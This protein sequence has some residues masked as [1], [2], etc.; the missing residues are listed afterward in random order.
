MVKIAVAGGSGEV[1]QEVV[2][3][4]GA[5]KKHDILILSRTDAP[6][7]DVRP[8][9]S[10]VKVNYEDR[11]QLTEIL[12]GVHTVLSFIVAHM[13]PG[14]IAQK[15]LIDAAIAAGVKRFAPSEWGS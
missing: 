10:W 5:T 1:G 9:V 4:L 7:G 2:D 3:A 14:S 13:D 12:R 8:D 11:D 15:T 6:P